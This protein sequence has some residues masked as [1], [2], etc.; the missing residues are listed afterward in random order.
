M[1]VETA[2]EEKGQV[3]HSE[4]SDSRPICPNYKRDWRPPIM[5][6]LSG[7]C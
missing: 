2:A 5:P 3:E 7:G 6:H 4:S 1:T